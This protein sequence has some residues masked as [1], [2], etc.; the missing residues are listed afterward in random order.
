MTKFEAW[1]LVVQAT[2]GV[3]TIAVAVMAIW[4]DLIRSIIASPKLDIDLRSS[5]GELT[6]LSDETLARYY[7]LIVT[8]KRKWSPAKNVTT[9]IFDLEKLGPDGEW[10]SSMHHGPVPIYW[11]FGKLYTRLPSI[12]HERICDIGFIPKGNTFKFTTEFKPYNFEN[13]VNKGEKVRAHFVAVADNAISERT[14]IE[15][16]WDGTW[17]DGAKEMAKHLTV[18]RI[19]NTG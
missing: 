11:Q 15:I 17:V 5:E 16:A 18:K 7:H 9:Y 12:G 13:I 19:K 2:V 4:G 1:S 6:H 14:I 3:G 8:N 10:Q